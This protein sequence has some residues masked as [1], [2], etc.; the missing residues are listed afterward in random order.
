MLENLNDYVAYHLD[1]LEG[2]EAENAFHSLIEAPKEAVPLLIE[3]Y[4]QETLFSTRAVIVEII[5]Q[6]RDP[7]TVP[8][9]ATALRD[10]SEEVWKQALDGLVTIGGGIALE[11]LR[12]EKSS[13]PVTSKKVEWI[14]EAIKQ[15]QQEST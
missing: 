15:I 5:W 10:D 3:A 7:T 9:L 1:R 13:L 14:D 6:F 2:A 4:Q 12:S 11:A 8:F